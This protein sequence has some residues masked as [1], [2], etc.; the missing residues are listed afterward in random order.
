M[1]TVRQCEPDE[2][3]MSFWL[4]QIV[5]NRKRDALPP[6]CRLKADLLQKYP[7]KLPYNGATEA[8]W[9]I[10]EVSTIQELE[11]LWMKR[12]GVWLAEKRLLLD[13][14]A[15]GAFLGE[16]TARAH[17]TRF[18]ANHADNHD[19]G[20]LK[21]YLRWRPTGLAGVLD[22]YERPLIQQEDDRIGI[23]DGWGRLLPYLY[24]AKYE[25]LAFLP[26]Q[27]FFAKQKQ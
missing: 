27:C 19:T 11:Q 16:L 12:S 17:E 25:S 2:Y 21:T 26:F 15:S 14:N 6:P 10:C 8:T 4:R 5:V 24:L 9:E 1:K 3:L 13:P 22:S 23:V 20:Q 7:Y 18:F